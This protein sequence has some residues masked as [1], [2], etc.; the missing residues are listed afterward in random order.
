M[1]ASLGRDFLL[2]P[3]MGLLDGKLARAV[4]TAFESWPSAGAAWPF[5]TGA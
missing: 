4:R 2:R 3:V 1:S 5:P